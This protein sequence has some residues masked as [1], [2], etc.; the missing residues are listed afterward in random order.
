MQ[1]AIAGIQDAIRVDVIDIPVYLLRRAYRDAIDEGREEDRCVVLINDY[2]NFL[3]EF[4]PDRDVCFAHLPG[5]G[6]D[7]LLGR[8]AER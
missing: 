2:D 7:N 4:L 1:I 3:P 8:V 6:E 5:R